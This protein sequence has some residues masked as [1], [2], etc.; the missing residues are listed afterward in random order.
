MHKIVLH[1]IAGGRRRGSVTS[2]GVPTV[3]LLRP[4]PLGKLTQWIDAFSS[5]GNSIK[6]NKY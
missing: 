5:L 6:L 1:R 2:R 3:L 4:A